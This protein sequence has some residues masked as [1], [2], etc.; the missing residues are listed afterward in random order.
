L[1]NKEIKVIDIKGIA[2]KKSIDSVHKFNIE[3]QGK[4]K[5]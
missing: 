3:S 5:K 2:S 4:K 1:R